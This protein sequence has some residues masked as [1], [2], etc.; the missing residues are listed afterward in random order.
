MD[1]IPVGVAEIVSPNYPDIYPN[2]LNC[3]W[4]IYSASGSKLKTVI[5]DVV[6]EDA[7]DCIWDSLSFYDGPDQHSQLLG[8]LSSVF[9]SS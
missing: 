2:L 5:R 7:K 8:A 4:T 9:F 3:T 6:I 1:L